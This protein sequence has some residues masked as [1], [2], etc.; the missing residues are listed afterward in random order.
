MIWDIFSLSFVYELKNKIWGIHINLQI[1][2]DDSKHHNFI[3]ASARIASNISNQY[4]FYKLKTNRDIPIRNQTPYLIIIFESSVLEY[5]INCFHFNLIILMN[6]ENCSLYLP[7]FAIWYSAIIW[8]IDWKVAGNLSL[9]WQLVLLF[10][11]FVGFDKVLRRHCM[12][13][14]K[15]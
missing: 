11:K 14:D 6:T 3:G 9:L 10:D 15:Y 5:V 13:R 7:K 8:V 1:L 2:T 4:Q 12:R